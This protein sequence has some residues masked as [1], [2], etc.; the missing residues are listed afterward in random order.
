[1]SGAK[2]QQKG[3]SKKSEKGKTEVKIEH[4]GLGGLKKKKRAGVRSKV[5]IRGE[6]EL[7]L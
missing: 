6:E 3:Y 4:H 1:L 5:G 7:K 2:A